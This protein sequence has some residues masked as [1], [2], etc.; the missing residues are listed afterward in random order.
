MRT[1][2]YLKLNLD[3][4]DVSLYESALKVIKNAPPLSTSKP[5]PPQDKMTRARGFDL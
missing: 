3:E 4:Q 5:T 2:K 1:K